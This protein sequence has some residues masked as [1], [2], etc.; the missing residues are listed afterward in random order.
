VGTG[1]ELGA[2]AGAIWQASDTLSF[3]FGVRRARMEGLWST[4]VRAGLTLSI[5]G[6]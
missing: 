2:L 4:E 1:A 3:D 5:A 6:L